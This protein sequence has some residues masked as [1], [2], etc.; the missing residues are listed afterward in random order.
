MSR[1]WDLRGRRAG[2]IFPSAR[3]HSCWRP[4]PANGN[5]FKIFTAV[6]VMVVND[7][8]M[9]KIPSWFLPW[10]HLDL[11]CLS[12]SYSKWTVVTGVWSGRIKIFSSW[13][14]FNCDLNGVFFS[15]RLM[16]NHSLFLIR[17]HSHLCILIDHIRQGASPAWG[18]TVPVLPLPR[19]FQFRCYSRS[20]SGIISTPQYDWLLIIH[21]IKM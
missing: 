9:V 20:L 17:F 4:T 1:C 13:L 6:M 5:I 16:L 3:N 10:S 7:M 11:C 12:S 14:A 8:F 19:R 18:Q 15:K 2:G 21:K